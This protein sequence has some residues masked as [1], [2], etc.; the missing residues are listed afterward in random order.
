[1]K[2]VLVC[3]HTYKV[4]LPKLV[5]TTHSCCVKTSRNQSRHQSRN[6]VE[7]SIRQVHVCFVVLVGSGEDV[8]VGSKM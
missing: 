5:C 2:I 6:Q 1:M 8:E 7:T 4:H 3:V